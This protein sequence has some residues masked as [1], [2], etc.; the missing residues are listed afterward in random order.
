MADVADSCEECEPSTS[1]AE[2]RENQVVSLLDR[3][4]PPDTSDFS[5]ERTFNVNRGGKG[6]NRRSISRNAK[7]NY[8]PQVSAKK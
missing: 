5:R 2:A 6:G 3:L 7:P 4:R 1:F 8:A